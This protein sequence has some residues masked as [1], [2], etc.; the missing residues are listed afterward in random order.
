LLLL[1]GEYSAIE[2][3]IS[4]MQVELISDH[5]KPQRRRA[6]LDEIRVAERDLEL[7]RDDISE[8][9]VALNE[10]HRNLINMKTEKI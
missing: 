6:L 1:Q 10:M 5:V 7:L 8:A 9:D 4:S 3:Q 2:E